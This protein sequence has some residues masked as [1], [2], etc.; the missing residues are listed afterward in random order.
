MMRLALLLCGDEPLTAELVQPLLDPINAARD[1][2]DFQLAQVLTLLKR[3]PQIPDDVRD[4]MK[5]A[6]LA[7][8]Y[9][10]DEPRT[11]DMCMWS[12]NHYALF[13]VCELI[14]GQMYPEDMFGNF[15]LIGTQRAERGR[16]RLERW[17]EWRF[18]FGFSEWHS[19]TYYVEDAV[20]LALAIDHTDLA[21][22]ATLVMDI[23]MLDMAIHRFEGRF[24]GSS[25]R[26]YEAEK[27]DPGKA[28]V[29][30]ILAVAFGPGAD[31]ELG[32]LSSVFALSSY[33]VP[34][35][36]RSIA[37]QDGDFVCRDSS[38]L[39]ITEAR[40]LF[41]DDVDTAGVLLW[42]ME[43][44][45]N[46]EAI[47]V[48]MAAFKKWNLSRNRFLSGLTPFTKVP[49]GK[50][51]SPL[52]SL[53]R[54]LN[55]ITQGTA[56][57]RANVYSFRTRAYHL[58]SV[59]SHHA[60]EFGDQQHLWQA[61]LPGDLTVFSTHPGG[62]R[63]PGS[64]RN[65]TPSEWVGNGINP[66][67]GQ[68]ENVLLVLHDVRGRGGYLEKR[69]L[70]QSHLYLPRAAFDETRLGPDWFVGRKDEAFIAIRSLANLE[71]VATDE[72]VQRGDVTGYAVMCFD[73]LDVTGIAD[74]VA[75]IKASRL[76]YHGGKLTFATG[77]GE[78]SV[79]F[80]KG[81]YRNGVAVDQEFARYDNPWVQAARDPQTIDILCQG[82]QVTL[83]WGAG[84]RRI[85]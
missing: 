74:L 2:A 26:S 4:A 51:I 13:A 43:A 58:S 75:T 24:V 8:P 54:S 81:L 77:G 61:T 83:D 17:L 76:T 52:R 59:Q 55:P 45:T 39:D 7:F 21:E 40:R 19:P 6:V 42:Q 41:G 80:G 65:I 28:D 73:S 57:Q 22:R 78:F 25:G 27:K 9:W 1:C 34:L 5:Q 37:E 10:L 35:A 15:A 23:L 49:S 3:V 56:L 31:P 66:E 85:G 48:T 60:G 71:M 64:T 82:H 47:D 18:R 46:V 68:L 72:I 53:V 67:I 84:H 29:N 16:E 36:I 70:R 20:A 33:D 12:E 44:F 30:E 14:A 38:G 79:V 69:R 50:R 32:R 62:T 63:V 11:D